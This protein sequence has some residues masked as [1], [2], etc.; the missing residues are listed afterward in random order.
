ML[1]LNYYPL[2]AG[3]RVSHLG[4]RSFPHPA[5]TDHLPRSGLRP[6]GTPQPHP[7]GGA[8]PQPFGS[9]GVQQFQPSQ[10]AG[11]P[12]GQRVNQLQGPAGQDEGVPG[13]CH[14]LPGQQHAA[15][16][17]GRSFLPEDEHSHRVV[18]SQQQTTR[19]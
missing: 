10:G 18:R 9:T 11:R 8:V 13:Q 4:P 16:L 7:A 19:E 6:E 1:I 2:A 12:A 15:Q 14:G 5:A 17:A 3:D